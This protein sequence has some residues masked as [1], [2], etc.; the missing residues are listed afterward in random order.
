LHNPTGAKT[1][2]DAQTD[3]NINIVTN[4]ELFAHQT[5]R[6]SFRQNG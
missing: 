4:E 1:N 6:S 3:H 2:L 5:R